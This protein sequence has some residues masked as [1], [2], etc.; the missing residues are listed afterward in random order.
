MKTITFQI[1][2]E[3]KLTGHDAAM[4]VAGKLYEDGVL[5]TGEAAEFVGISKREFLETM[6]TY[7]YSIF[8]DKTEDLKHDSEAA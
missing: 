6:G 7:G 5:S 1:P 8:S 2:D 4:I 3:I